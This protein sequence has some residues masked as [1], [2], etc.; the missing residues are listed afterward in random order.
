VDLQNCL[1]DRTF[2][3]F[4]SD[5]V[6]DLTQYL[7]AQNCFFRFSPFHLYSAYKITDCLFDQ[8]TFY[9]LYGRGAVIGSNNGYT[10]GSPLVPGATGGNDKTNLAAN[11][12][13]GPLGPYYYPASGGTNTLAALLNAGSRGAD[14][15]GLYHYTTQINQAKETNSIVEIGFHY[16]PVEPSDDGLVAR[17][18]LDEGSGY[19]AND[20]GPYGQ[21]GVLVN[22]PTWTTG[23]LG[24]AL[25]FDGSNDQVTVNDSA[26][27]RISGD[28]TIAFWTKKNS[29]ATLI[30]RLIGKG[31]TSVRNYGIWEEAGTSK[32]LLF[33]QLDAGGN[34]IN[35]WTTNTLTTG[36]WYHVA[37]VVQG[38][39]AYFYINGA[40]D[41]SGTR[42]ASAPATTDPLTFGYAGWND[43]YPGVLDDI[44]IYNRALSATEIGWLA[45][46]TWD[47]DGDGIPDYLEDSNGDGVQN[48]SD[49]TRDTDGDG[50]IDREDADR[51][52]PKVGRLNVI[53]FQPGNGS[54]VN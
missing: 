8:P 22:S 10:S 12:L 30:S 9:S 47:S 6:S 25:N 46:K 36:T 52:N 28:L 13:S 49:G 19:I 39:N 11:F 4:K 5:N 27:L 23:T 29:E 33:Q 14:Q 34:G 48:G 15:A 42:N 53:I 16:V 1:F 31:N 2:F 51:L 50:V 26:T 54:S 17:W 20:S 7:T 18:R 3:W 43:Y 24:G 32:R 35:L 40:V 45:G 41:N 37:A 38:N 21:H 44:R